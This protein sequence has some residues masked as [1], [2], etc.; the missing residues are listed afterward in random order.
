MIWSA[1]VTVDRRCATHQHC[2]QLGHVRDR[3][4][5]RRL[6]DRVKLRRTSASSSSVAPGAPKVRF[7][8]STSKHPKLTP[9][10]RA[11]WREWIDRIAHVL[12]AVPAAADF[13]SGQLRL[14]ETA[15]PPPTV[16]IRLE[17]PKDLA[18]LIGTA[19][20]ETL[21]GKQHQREA[22]GYFVALT[23]GTSAADAAEQM[24]MHVLRYALQADV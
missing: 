5:Q 2:D 15:E 14:E 7:L 16:A 22:R 4:P 17:T 23:D 13:L 18:Q 19:R 24:V 20:L 11:D 10:A 12:Q 6:V 3:F 1:M 8:S 21:P 9:A